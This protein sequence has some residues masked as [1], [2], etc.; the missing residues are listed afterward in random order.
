MDKFDI[1]TIKAAFWDT[2]HKRG[3]IFFKYPIDEHWTEQDCQES[4][5]DEWYTFIDNLEK[6]ISQL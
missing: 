2:F 6:Y 1:E 3:D 5:T 4:T